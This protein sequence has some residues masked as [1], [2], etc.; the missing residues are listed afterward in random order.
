MSRIVPD[1]STLQQH[2]QQ[3]TIAPQRYHPD[4]CP[5]CGCGKLWGHGRYFRYPDRGLL[6]RGIYNP[7]TIPRYYCTACHK[8]CSRLPSCIAP[9]RWY[10]WEIQQNIL[11]LLLSGVSLNAVS[12]RFMPSRKTIKRWSTWVVER[13]VRFRFWLATFFADLERHA[14]CQD[15]WYAALH[16]HKLS[17]LMTT[18]DN[19]GVVVP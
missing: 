13:S 12:N 19:Q 11:R 4:R 1:I 5:H 10:I 8:T 18:L 14:D 9:R 6:H 2:Q 15:Y 7:A 16:T 17:V 3:I